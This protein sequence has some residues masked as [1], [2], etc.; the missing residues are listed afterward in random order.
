MTNYIQFN[1][2]LK[3][4]SG[5]TTDEAVAYI[6]NY[7]VNKNVT[8]LPTSGTTQSANINFSIYKSEVDYVAGEQPF[9][10]ASTTIFPT[11]VYIQ[12]ASTLTDDDIYQKVVDYFTAAG[13]SV[14][15]QTVA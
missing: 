7:S 15:L 12:D 14:T 4:V 6:T 9:Q 3:S 11:S 2:T 5:F 8:V 10:I 1:Q 13:Y